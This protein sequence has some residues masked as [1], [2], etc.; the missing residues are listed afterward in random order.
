MPITTGV[1]YPVPVTA[2][3]DLVG[4]TANV[5]STALFTA[6]SAGIYK[7]GALE[8]LTTPGTTSSVL[9]AVSITYTDAD[10]NVVKTVTV[11]DTTT[12]ALGDTIHN[13]GEYN[14]ANNTVVSFSTAS[15]ASVGAT[16]MA[17]ALH[18]RCQYLDPSY[19]IGANP[20]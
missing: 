4:Q 2:T 20:E 19:G 17:Y 9:P 3:A 6:R 16:P 18:I 10:T 5:A 7:I 15:Y 14:V 13:F 11:A 12:N 1:Q 8:V